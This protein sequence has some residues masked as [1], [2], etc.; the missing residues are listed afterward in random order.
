MSLR[1]AEK[2]V[3]RAFWYTAPEELS[4][5]W[6]RNGLRRLPR[7]ASEKI[8]H[9]ILECKSDNG[10]QEKIGGRKGGVLINLDRLED[11]L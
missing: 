1:R 3:G 6:R 8:R 5:F 11:R 10:S 9:T 7:G 2:G 4:Q